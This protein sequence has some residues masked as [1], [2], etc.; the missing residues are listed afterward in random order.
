[1][2]RAFAF[3]AVALMLLADNV[4][5]AGIGLFGVVQIGKAIGETRT[6]MQK[7][8]GRRALHAEIAVRSPGHHPVS[9][10]HLTLPTIYSV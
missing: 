4:D 3:L 1:M 9:Y 6:E 7:R 2:I 10:T 5:D 8:R